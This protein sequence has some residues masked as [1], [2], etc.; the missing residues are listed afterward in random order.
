VSTS[1]AR[2]QELQYRLADLDRLADVDKQT[3]QRQVHN[4]QNLLLLLKVPMNVTEASGTANSMDQ[5]NLL[6]DDQIALS[7][8]TDAVSK[9]LETLC[10]HRSQ[11]GEALEVCR[12]LT[13][14]G[15]HSVLQVR[16]LCILGA[17]L[18]CATDVAG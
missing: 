7:G 10:A 18:D 14:T 1:Q 13:V 16:A 9:G 15:C 8:A 2:V 5:L 12:I 3:L 17:E 4:L 6:R 11:E